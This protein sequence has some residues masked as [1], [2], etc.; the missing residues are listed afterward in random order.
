MAKLPITDQFL[1][2]LVFP[3]LN[4]A[5]NIVDFLLSSRYRQ[6][7]IVMGNGNPIIRKY[8]KDKNRQKFNQLIYHLKKNNYIKVKNLESKKA[9][10]IT[11]EGLDKVLKASFKSEKKNKRKDGKW[12]MIIFDIPQKHHKARSL[13]RSILQNLGYKIFQQS[14]WVTPYDV[15]EKTEKLLQSYSLDEYVK[16]FLIE[17]L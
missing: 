1:L 4:A 7:R 10:I 13:L 6:V 11:K 16:I 3:F 5:D 14:V 12:V 17:E 9:I 2:D 8:K 15:S